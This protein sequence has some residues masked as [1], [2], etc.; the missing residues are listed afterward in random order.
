VTTDLGDPKQLSILKV[1]RG[2]TFSLP[3]SGIGIPLG[4]PGQEMRLP[5]TAMIQT[6]IEETKRRKWRGCK[7][8]VPQYNVTPSKKSLHALCQLI[9]SIMAVIISVPLLLIRDYDLRHE[10]TKWLIIVSAAQ[11]ARNRGADL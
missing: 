2:S 1:L 10:L 9:I 7:R 5:V 4:F 8:I 11:I 6:M 3:A